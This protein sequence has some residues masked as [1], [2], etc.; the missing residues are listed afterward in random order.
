MATILVIVLVFAILLAAEWLARRTRIHAELTRKFIHMT[1][2]T[3]VAFWPY[4]LTWYQIELLSAAFLAVILVSIKLNIFTAIHNV[5]RSAIGEIMFAAVIGLLAFVCSGSDKW[6]FTAA[7]L[8]LSLGDGLAAVIGIGWGDG[9][10]Y[11][12]F[13]KT[14]SVAGTSAF[15]LVSLS[16]MVAYTH[17]GHAP[18]T[19]LT[20]LVIP[21]LATLTENVAVNGTDNLIMP[22]LVALL[23]SST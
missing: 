2:G 13:G 9:N 22:L 16:V 10:Q 15:L 20:L 23:L 21:L 6:V 7:M 8:N 1:V 12:V 4:L 14:K 11:K 3:I 18:A 19:A 17:F 5:D